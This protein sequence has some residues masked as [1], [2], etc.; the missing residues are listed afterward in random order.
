MA[1][2]VLGPRNY[3]NLRTDR[4]KEAQI[5]FS[6]PYYN[7]MAFLKPPVTEHGLARFTFLMRNDGKQ[8]LRYAAD[9][10]RHSNCARV[11]G[12]P[13]L[14]RRWRFGR[15][16]EGLPT[17]RKVANSVNTSAS[18]R[19]NGIECGGQSTRRAANSG[20]SSG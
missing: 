18:A 5:P 4:L 11:T 20:P 6:T 15:V 3:L 1:G 17:I 10:R 19:S 16:T 13:H 9:W 12:N 2:R 8:L 7:T 14:T